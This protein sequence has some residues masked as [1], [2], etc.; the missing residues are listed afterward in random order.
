[1]NIS[2]C[3]PVALNMAFDYILPPELEG[4]AALGLRV[5]VPFGKAVQT[6]YIT[7]LN[8]TPKLPPTV[9][10]KPIISIEDKRPFY[11]P[12]LFP[13]A[14]FI[15]QNYANTLGETLGVLIPSI[16]NQKMLDSYKEPAPADL[17]FF[18]PAGEYT[19]EQKNALKNAR[20]NQINLF[21]GANLSGKTEAALSLAYDVLNDGGQVL[22]L[23][24][25]VISS[26]NLIEVINKKFGA[27]HIHL[28]H[29]KV[30][31]SRR[32]TAAAEML[33]GK[34]C[35][36][37][38]TRSACLLPFKNL[39][40]TIIFREE[41][42]DFKQEDAK[43]YYHAREVAVERAK[44][45]G[46]KVIMVS[47]TPSLE[48][49][50]LK[51][52]G[53][54]KASL[55]TKPLPAF[56]NN[57][58]VIIAPKNGKKSKLISDVLAEALHQNML[59]GGQ[60]LVI[61]NRLGY[62]RIYA[63]LNCGAYAKCKK[64]GAFLSRVKTLKED[65]LICRKC[66]HK[67]TLQQVC[68]VCKNEIFRSHGGGTQAAAEEIYKL[69]PQ[70]RV[71]RL[72]SQ[73]LNT[74]KSEGHFVEEA[75][76]DGQADII[77]GTNLALNAGLG[78]GKINLAALL[79]ADTELNAADF[80]AAERFAQTLF[81]LKSR[82][83]RYKNAKLFIQTSKSDLFDF[84]LLKENKYLE[85]AQAEAQFRRDFAFPPYTKLVKLLI[86]AKNEKDL[87]AY[88][89]MTVKALREAYGAFMNIEGPVKCGAQSK[90]L[91]RQYYLIKSADDDMLKGF[92]NTL[93]NN[94]PPKKIQLKVLADPY[95]FI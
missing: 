78:G 68:P 25:D 8:T 83:N 24:P 67:E 20:E 26:A 39:K 36:T 29:S 55:F 75:L 74:K 72:D 89:D 62:S 44:L 79:D 51:E 60:S 95:N 31:L 59:R 63:C 43:P 65:Y 86:S 80:R 52:D 53:A 93:L 4:C 38:G 66:G 16:F 2:V 54:L 64:C 76:K 92:L 94:K 91:C 11:G 46:G 7:A 56:T 40:L 73:T 37:V 19:P 61:L 21:Y 57:T 35:L 90:E 34:P 81:A 14:K 50:K 18:Y 13:L 23:V 3:I 10:L 49:L 30:L 17:P 41:S 12:E 42:K 5:K 33:L 32:K 28:W 15:E 69:F 45:T 22:V 70:A 87:N 47:A 6:G 77:V 1:M 88:G 58:E 71:Y 84:N 48:T 85:F 9:K 82:L 27:E